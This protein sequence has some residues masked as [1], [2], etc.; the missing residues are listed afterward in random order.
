MLNETTIEDLTMDCNVTNDNHRR[1][2]HGLQSPIYVTIGFNVDNVSLG[3]D[4]RFDG[5]LDAS[6]V[7]GGHLIKQTSFCTN[8]TKM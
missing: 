1:L 8:S 6:V 3:T 5:E 4:V 7:E 2:N